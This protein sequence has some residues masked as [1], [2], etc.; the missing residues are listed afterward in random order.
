[1]ALLNYLMNPR[2]RT[3]APRP[4]PRASRFR[5]RQVMGNFPFLAGLCIVL[6]LLLLA[7]GGPRLAR[8]N[9]YLAGQRSVRYEDGQFIVPPFPPSPE[10]PLGTDQWGRDILSLLLYGARNTLT[11]ALFVTMTHLLLG[12]SLGAMAGWNEGKWIDRTVMGIVEVLASLPL[13]LV[14]MM[15]IFALDIRRGL[16]V[17]IVALCLV[18]WGEM[19]Q[20][21][22]AEF[23][24]L[25]QR[26]FVE[27]A[28]AIGL[29]GLGIAIRHI[30]PNMLPS[31]IAITFLDMG[32]VLTLMGE[33]GFVDVFIGGGVQVE[34][35][36]FRTVTIPD[37]PEWG[38][39]LAGARRYARS[40]PWVTFWPALAFFV[41]VVGF[42]LLGEGLRRII[43]EAGVNTAALLSK[44]MLIG[45]AAIS[46]VTYYIVES[47]SPR[48]SYTDLARVFLEARA[49]EDLR[50][51]AAMDRGVGTAGAKEAA[52]YI[53]RQFEKAGLQ[54]AG[55]EGTYFQPITVRLVH[56][57]EPPELAVVDE[58]G[59]VLEDFRR[60]LDFGERIERHGGSGEAEAPLTFIAFSEGQ[61]H[62]SDFKGLDLRGHIAF[63]FHDNA[64]PEFDTEALIRGALGVLVVAENCA[65]Q[66]QL[67][68]PN[69]DY[70]EMPTFPVFFIC[71]AAAER[72]LAS[73]G[74][75]LQ[76][77][78]EEVAS[79]SG[80]ERR[81]KALELGVRV[82]MRLRL[83]DVEEAEIVNVLGLLP[84][85]DVA[86][87]DELLVICAHYD[88]P[89]PEPDS[90]RFIG[91]N[92]GASG[93]SLLLEIARAWKEADFKP[94]RTVLFAAWAGGHLAY[95]GA[96]GYLNTLSAFR[97]LKPVGVIMLGKVGGG[98]DVLLLEGTGTLPRLLEDSAARMGI[99][100]K[101]ASLTPHP[102]HEVLMTQASSVLLGWEPV[103]GLTPF[104]DT[105]EG[106]RAEKLGTVGRAVN[107]ALITASRSPHF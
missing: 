19:A 76:A 96:H 100:T 25:R 72:M 54:A 77:L 82:R 31:L 12:F 93:I 24:S 23:V 33:L 66:T 64:P 57:L 16:P 28:R 92:D 46:L 2:P 81:W 27:G 84:G 47:I 94:R 34:D 61:F 30:L 67:A 37:I 106:I 26:P 74:L 14:G 55:K 17:F 85:A 52:S 8:E 79:L 97:S 38:A 83:G 6:A 63:Y 88:T 45:M 95:S 15:L 39:M 32:A 21:V 9:P 3:S 69:E 29:N 58:E 5:W 18:G 98:G 70:M 56:P 10:F 4:K 48:A 60:W 22:R 13:L 71:P 90:T 35:M 87:D 42:N 62:P 68:P 104:E 78:R 41:A 7:L 107:L 89:R 20:H 1:M 75:T 103:A 86:L 43:E 99:H 105:T 51:L 50:L 73:Q 36:E 65:P 91:A 59:E 80:E 49:M 44:W 101:Q 40:F 53:A 102:Y 11:T